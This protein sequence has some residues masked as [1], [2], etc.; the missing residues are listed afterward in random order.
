MV[1]GLV[2]HEHPDLSPPVNEED[3]GTRPQDEDQANDRQLLDAEAVPVDPLLLA[4]QCL[5]LLIRYLGGNYG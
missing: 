4:L 5:D 3:Y 1:P 2:W